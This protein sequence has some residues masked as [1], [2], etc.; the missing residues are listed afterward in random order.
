LRESYLAEYPD[1]VGRAPRSGRP[2]D[3]RISLDWV[4]VLARGWKREYPQLDFS[5]LRP[6]VRLA[7]LGALIE[8]IQNDVLEPFELTSSDYG[9]LTALRN[10]GR[11]YALSPSQ[12]HGQLRRSSGGM[13]KILKRLE[14]S[15]LVE[16]ESDTEDGR[17]IRV[18]LTPRG[19]ALHD[20]VFRAFTAASN[21]LLT[22]LTDQ[23]KTEI[24]RAL[25]QLHDQME[26]LGD[27]T[28]S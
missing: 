4:D 14:E 5:S 8:G 22:K 15:N 7:R 11:P 3:R 13:T 21:R 1:P 2:G 26:G 10:V 25:A 18:T 23:Q 20:R 9:A 27:D 16:R 19:L 17:K 28:A 24:D 6:F 12:L